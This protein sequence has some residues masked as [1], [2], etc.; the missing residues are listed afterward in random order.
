MKIICDWDNCK[1]LG[2]YKAP[3]ERDNSKTFKLLCLNHIKIFN[4]RSNRHY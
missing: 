2:K 4:K 3:L 1:E